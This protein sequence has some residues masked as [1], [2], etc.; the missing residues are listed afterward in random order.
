MCFYS[1]FA[2]VSDR[3]R[4]NI[5]MLQAVAG[6]LALSL[7]WTGIRSNVPVDLAYG[8]VCQVSFT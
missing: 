6:R 2:V 4:I 8:I 3:V 7:H 5:V 1:P